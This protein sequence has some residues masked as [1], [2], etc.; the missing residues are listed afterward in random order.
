[1]TTGQLVR[2]LRPRLRPSD[3]YAG[4]GLAFSDDGKELAVLLSGSDGA[5]HIQAWDFETGKR[6]A[7]HAFGTS[8]Q[9]AAKNAPGFPVPLKWLPNR[10]GWL[11]YEKLMIDHDRGTIFWRLA[12]DEPT[13]ILWVRRFLG[14]DHVVTVVDKGGG[15]RQLEILA[16]PKDEIA[17]AR[18]K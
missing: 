13:G 8:L 4:H 16:L 9:K 1:M 14:P 7:D 10:A 15:K 6:T 18:K 3:F 11:A 17:A 2:T 5:D 12:P